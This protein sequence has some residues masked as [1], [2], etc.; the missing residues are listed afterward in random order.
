MNEESR[1]PLH[2]ELAPE[3]G[4]HEIH[5]A[6]DDPLGYRPR[7]PYDRIRAC[8]PTREADIPFLDHE[9]PAFRALSVDDVEA[10]AAGRFVEQ[11][12]VPTAAKP[13]EERRNRIGPGGC[14]ATKTTLPRAWSG[15]TPRKCVDLGMGGDGIEPPTSWV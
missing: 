13:L 3:Q 2:L 1:I 11:R 6:G 4:R 14:H 12:L 15:V 8:I 7:G 5:L 9:E 10:S